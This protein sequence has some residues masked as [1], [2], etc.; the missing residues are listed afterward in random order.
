MNQI[1]QYSQDTFDCEGD[2]NKPFYDCESCKDEA[3][4]E[5]NKYIME[6]I[7]IVQSF[8]I[9][10][11]FTIAHNFYYLSTIGT[12]SEYKLFKKAIRT[13]DLKI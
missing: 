11:M 13:P 6:M 2:A 3:L 7:K 1:T 10:I 9:C 4:H 12:F 5:T 8:F